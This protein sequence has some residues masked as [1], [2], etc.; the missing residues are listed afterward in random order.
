[1]QGCVLSF[2]KQ[3]KDGS[4]FDSL[5]VSQTVYVCVGGGGGDEF[6][7]RISADRWLFSSGSKNQRVRAGIEGKI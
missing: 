2:C 1:M 5:C 6:V 7:S 4:C 3:E